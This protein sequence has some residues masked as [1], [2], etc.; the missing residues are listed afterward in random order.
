MIWQ[1][2]VVSQPPLSAAQSTPS[3]REGRAFYNSSSTTEDWAS[4]GCHVDWW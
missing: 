2:E 4:C 3:L 1:F